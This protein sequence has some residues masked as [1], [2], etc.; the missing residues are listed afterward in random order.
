MNIDDMREEFKQYCGPEEMVSFGQLT[1][2]D[3][4]KGSATLVHL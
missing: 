1:D 4:E 2:V 3:P